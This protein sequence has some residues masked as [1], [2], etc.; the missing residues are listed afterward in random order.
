MLNQIDRDRNEHQPIDRLINQLMVGESAVVCRLSAAILILIVI[1]LPSLCRRSFCSSLNKLLSVR[2]VCTFLFTFL[3][4]AK[5]TQSISFNS[6]SD[7][8]PSPI[9]SSGLN[10]DELISS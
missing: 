10:L 9:S 3:F 8:F 6:N 5:N 1:I 4:S 7:A 2:F